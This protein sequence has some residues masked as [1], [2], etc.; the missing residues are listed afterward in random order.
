VGGGKVCRTMVGLI[1]M[2]QDS[3]FLS[4]GRL[5]CVDD[6]LFTWAEGC[7]CLI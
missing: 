5:F 6:G 1:T 7:E 2:K 4:A 3:K